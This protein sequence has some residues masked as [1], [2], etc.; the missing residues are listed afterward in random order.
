MA[1]KQRRLDKADEEASRVKALLED[2]K[3]KLDDKILKLNETEERH[4]KRE[5][6]NSE[7]LAELRSRIEEK[8]SDI[9]QKEA[10]LGE[11]KCQ[12]IDLQSQLTKALSDCSQALSE[13]SQSRGDSERTDGLLKASQLVQSELE[14]E[15]K[16]LG[17]E[18]R[19]LTERLQEMSTRMSGQ[20]N[21]IEKLKSNLLESEQKVLAMESEL[22]TKGD[23]LA[24]LDSSLQQRNAE[25]QALHT[26]QDEMN[27]GLTAVSTGLGQGDKERYNTDQSSRDKL[28]PECESFD[29]EENHCLHCGRGGSELATMQLQFKN[30]KEHLKDRTECLDRVRQQE[31]SQRGERSRLICRMDKLQ[32]EMNAIEKDNV[33][34]MGAIRKRD[35]QLATLSDRVASYSKGGGEIA[36]LKD[37]VAQRINEIEHLS[38]LLTVQESLIVKRSLE[39]DWMSAQRVCQ[40]EA[41]NSS[42][43]IE[44]ERKNK[45]VSRLEGDCDRL[46]EESRKLREKLKK[47]GEILTKER[48]ASREKERTRTLTEL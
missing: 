11:M 41:Q 25:I 17:A 19:H 27:R 31:D 3:S 8:E 24:S 6:K 9:L 2:T 43:R 10:L 7:E 35:E 14:E 1:G 12:S 47:Q 34:L 13:L 48:I 29:D 37:I 42:L 4:I 18:V 15:N 16:R 32:K 45:A 39:P 26:K 20:E 33:R 28:V 21:S 23:I 22:N 38:E 5:K 30:L 46:Q 36:V 40:I 44:V